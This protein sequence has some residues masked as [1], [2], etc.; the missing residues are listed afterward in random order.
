PSCAAQGHISAFLV[1]DDA[2]RMITAVIALPV[3]LQRAALDYLGLFKP[4]KSALQLKRANRLVCELAAL[5]TD[6]EVCRDERSGVRRPA[7]VAMWASGIEIMLAQRASL[8]LP[9]DGHGYLRAVVFGLADKADAAAEREKESNARAGRHL[10]KSSQTSNSSVIE[11]PLQRQLA[12][13][14]QQVQYDFMNDE[15]AAKARAEARQRYGGQ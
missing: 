11:S 12:W 10:V 3:E 6:G 5:A 13:I 2:K 7:T 8:T 15:E 9:L 4:P 14:A 1:E